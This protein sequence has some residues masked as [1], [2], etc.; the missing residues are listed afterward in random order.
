MAIGPVAIFLLVRGILPAWL[1]WPVLSI[2]GLGVVLALAGAVR[3]WLGPDAASD[4]THSVG[5]EWDPDESL[6]LSHASSR[7]FTV[8]IYL[9]LLC[10]VLACATVLLDGVW[11]TGPTDEMIPWLLY[12]SHLAVDTILLGMVSV[13]VPEPSG[14]EAVGW[15]GQ[16]AT[17]LLRLTVAAGALSVLGSIAISA[18][19]PREL[20]NGTVRQLA[21]HVWN[22]DVSDD[23]ALTIHRVAVVR[24]LPESEVLT[25]SKGELY[26]RLGLGNA[27]SSDPSADPT[28]ESP[29]PNDDDG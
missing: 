6:N 27:P 9:T 11:F 22:T 12:L 14:I 28:A 25:F 10:W 23:D 5:T 17:V 8:A 26:Q 2:A 24:P 21:D 4:P 3:T 29:P 1:W 15:L 20:F 18:F 16:A 19:R 7:G 13:V